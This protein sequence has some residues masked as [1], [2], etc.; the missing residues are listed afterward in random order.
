MSS[1]N[2][3]IWDNH[4]RVL[5]SNPELHKHTDW[6]V[7]DPHTWWEFNYA[8]M[9]GI[10]WFPQA[11]IYRG[12]KP[13]GPEEFS[14]DDKRKK[15]ALLF[16]EHFNRPLSGGTIADA[17]PIED[18]PNIISN[19]SLVWAD[20]VVTHSTEPMNNWWPRV[21]GDVCAAVHT[22]RIKCV[23]AGSQSY[24]QVPHSR[25]F[26]QQ[27]S[28]FNYVVRA[29]SF[30]DTGPT[31]VPFKKYMF[32]ILMG[33]VKTAR[34]FLM[35][36]LLESN[37]ID[38]CL[39]NLQP[40]PWPDPN[41]IGKI[42][43]QGVAK[44][45]QIEK[46]TSPALFDL[47]QPVV[48]QFKRQTQFLDARAQYSVNLVSCVGQSLPGDNVPMSVIIPWPVYQSSW[49]SVVCETA[50]IG[51]SNNF[52]T[53]KTAKCLF[54]K[55]VFIMFN[56]AGLLKRL[57]ELGFQTFHGDIIDE[58]YDSEPN[59]A[60]RYAMAW[61]QI[62]RLYHTDNPRLVYQ[63]FEQVLEHNHQHI[64]Q[65]VDRQLT[66]IKNFIHQPLL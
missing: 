37:F 65:L 4:R 28:F 66:D 25:F 40:R 31:T 5:T 18:H 2:F 59:D 36:R 27:M 14:Y 26:T 39:I 17:G 10:E 55:R 33:T 22:D 12:V 11:Q 48:Q 16:F 8:L 42:D 23:F 54:A 47:E 50:D 58:S 6:F 64:H 60:K 20:L 62:V 3:Y 41:Y 53:E 24:T 30:Q 34:T 43:P 45:G 9:Q 49:Y 32:D 46:Y 38:H 51:N 21:Y 19:L 63:Q 1:S 44:H 13:P 57:K 52:L 15:V 35:Y 61:Q 29:N 56:G 7:W